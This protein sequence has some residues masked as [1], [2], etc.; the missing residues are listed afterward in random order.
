M[1]ARLDT[2]LETWGR[3]SE[4]EEDSPASP[5]RLCYDPANGI[6]LELVDYPSAATLFAQGSAS[7]PATLFGQL[8]DGTLV[9]L[10]DCFITNTSIGAGTGIGLPTKLC[11]NRAL[12]GRHVA[13]LEQLGVKKYSVELSSLANW[14]CVSPL[15]MNM[16]MTDGKRGIDAT[17]RFPDPIHIN[18]PEQEFDVA[19]AH[20]WN[21]REALLSFEVAWSAAVTISVHNSMTL[22]ALT[23]VAWQCQNLMSMLIGDHLSVK[24]IAIKP[25]DPVS[26]GTIVSPLQL[27]YQ[28]RGKHDHPDL[29]EAQMLLSYSLV[30]EQFPQIVAEWFARSEQAVLA[31]NVF[32]GSQLHESP[33]I[34]VRFLA[35]TPAAEAY[36]R[37]LETG[38]YMEKSEYEAAIAGFVGQIPETIHGDHRVSL[39]KRLEWG[40]EYSF[41][42]RLT[43]LLKRLPADVQSRIAGQ[44]NA[45]KFLA[46]VKD[47]RNYFTHLDH[48]SEQNALKGKDAFV[49]CERLRILVVANLLHDLGIKDEI[50]LSV[51]ERSR[52]FQHWMS[53][54]LSL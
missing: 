39:K 40:Y 50:L 34:E 6:E 4:N 7:S 8:V 11:V 36:H 22:G 33:A 35:A 15:K 45:S 2:A 12:F 5:G 47:T 54:D 25:V 24:S 21:A 16:P 42:K 32:F 20:K 3:F 27:I 37:S 30:K 1:K 51:L 18:L 44:V 53:Q 13:D 48:T 31:S 10:V 29:H 19:I 14:M 38:V 17:L 23:E 46:K 52:E 28:Q 9:T 43:D 26:E 41:L 49:A